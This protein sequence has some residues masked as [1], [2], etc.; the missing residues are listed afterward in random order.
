MRLMKSICGKYLTTL[1]GFREPKSI[2]VWIDW[3]APTRSRR[4]DCEGDRRKFRAVIL[5]NNVIEGR[6]EN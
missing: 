6:R 1:H 2:V 5:R 4:Y 3:C